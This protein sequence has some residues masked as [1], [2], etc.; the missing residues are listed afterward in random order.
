MAPEIVRREAAPCIATDLYSLAV[1]LFYVLMMGHPLVGKREL[2]F[3]CWDESAESELF[4]RAPLFVFDPENPENAPDDQVHAGVARNWVLFPAYL[5]QLFVQAF[6]DGLRDPRNGRVRESMWRFA[7]ARLR[8][9]IIRCDACGKENFASE[10]GRVRPCWLC[11]NP[12]VPGDALVIDNRRLALNLGTVVHGHHLRSDYDY[13]TIVGEVI[14]HPV[15][16]DVLGLCNRSGGPWSVTLPDG[17]I[18][19][20]EA[21]K[22]VRI[23][24][25]TAIDFGGPLGR[26]ESLF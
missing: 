2:A 12:V 4:G 20:V 8:D 19:I 3:E 22:S 23:A 7:I 15:R 26:V 6:T 1:V 25:G 17:E 16:G 13:D 10:E 21:T 14:A 24:P 18:R 9:S 11:D 5:R